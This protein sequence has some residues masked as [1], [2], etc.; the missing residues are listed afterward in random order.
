MAAKSTTDRYG[1]V[2]V[3]IHWV[4]A[5][6]ILLLFGLGLAAANAPDPGVKLVLLRI[7]VPLGIAIFALTVF[8]IVWWF[9]DRRPRPLAGMPGWQVTAEGAVRLLIYALVLVLGASGIVLL[10]LSGAPAVLFFHTPG[11]LADF[12]SFPPM[13][14]HYL[15]AFA[16]IGLA[17]LHVAA[18][19]C[20]QWIRRDHLLARMG[21]GRATPA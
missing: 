18:A 20:H 11:P 9:I 19:L 16:L 6:A 12:W 14:A 15:A 21:V 10:L 5:A 8:R 2:A 13:M 17:A 3:T 1:T 7:H 4:T